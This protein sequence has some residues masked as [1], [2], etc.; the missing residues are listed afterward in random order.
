MYTEKRA[1]S[2]IHKS[3]NETVQ[4]ENITLNRQVYQRL[5][6]ALS[7]G[8]RRQILFA[9][10]DDLNLRNRI[11]ARL[12]ST[13]AYPVGQV[14]YQRANAGEF[15]TPA[16]PRLVT[17]RLNLTDPNPIT[18]INQWLVNYP[19][20]LVGGS[21]D[22]PGRPLPIPAFQ[23]VGVEMLTKEPVAA[24]RLFLNYLRLSEQHLFGKESSRFLESSL[25]FW[26]SRPWL[27]AIQQSA[28]RFWH[29]RTGV[30]VFAGEPTP[31][32][33]NRDYG[34]VFGDSRNLE[35]QNFESFVFDHEELSREVKHPTPVDLT[36]SS[37]DDLLNQTPAKSP[38]APISNK[39]SFLSLSHINKELESLVNVT[40]NID[41]SGQAQGILA[42]IEQLHIQQAKGEDL[43]IAYQNLGNFY[44]LQIEQGDVT[45][46]NLMIAIL[47]YQEAVSHDESS[48]Q[49]PDIL[50]DLGTLYWMLHRIPDNAEEA[51]IY[52]QQGIDFYKL[53]LKLI[54]GDTQPET[55]AR[56]QN[57][58]GTAYGD[59]SKF[60]EP[61]ENWQAAV[62][63]YHEALHY[64]K[65]EI[66]PLKYAACQNNL[67]T[68]YW[69]LGQYNQP[70]ENLQKAIAA[71]KLASIH[72]QPAEEP[73]K[74]S[75][76]QNNIGTAYWNLSQYE[77]P[78]ENLQLAIQVYNEALKYRTSK[79][80]PHGYA[81]TQN[82]LG[83]AYW[84]LANQ[85][86]TTKEDKQQLVQ[87]CIHAYEEALKTAHS[88]SDLPLSFDIWVTHN[89]LGLAYYYSVMNIAFNRD[90]KTLSPALE[91]A[92]ENHLQALTGF[93]KE[94]EN[95]QTTISHIINTIRTFHNELGIQGQNVALS[96]L[97]GQLLPKILPE[98]S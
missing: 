94:T 12:H 67:G 30:F 91:S 2:Q 44:R 49:L 3:V 46:E 15:S 73:L 56:I 69:H 14:L 65:E 88:C 79:N 24:Q 97:P 78:M 87:F 48:P 10:C 75:M 32:I 86:Q 64:R 77:Q 25:L 68:A 62:I 74:Y 20:P 45:L 35:R 27:S 81:A 6:L 58:L 22:N 23:I 8:L 92:L 70:V 96:K 7:L 17:L 38:T 72:Y 50:N 82:N 26:V 95:Y 66:E 16:Y 11:A 76:I 84:H 29:C 57:N 60:A 40:L 98:L 21:S 63:A 42:E 52:I 59:L 43:A 54:T 90:K 89:N 4:T 41:N 36:V 34:E 19:P 39:Q 53:A 37:Q 9:I 51:K 1:K 13:L 80:V 5:K 55:Y 83:I 18:Q 93:A 61:V 31:T 85:S 33:D 47:S 71:Y 28:P